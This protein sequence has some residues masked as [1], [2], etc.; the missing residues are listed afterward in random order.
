MGRKSRFDEGKIARLVCMGFSRADVVKALNKHKWNEEKAL[1]S[2][3]NSENEKDP[4]L[5]LA[6]KF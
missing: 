1:N 5:T 4:D 6:S 3:L 2:I